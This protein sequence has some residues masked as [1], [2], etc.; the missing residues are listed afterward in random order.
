M[1]RAEQSL[2][3]I[4]TNLTGLTVTGAS[5]HRAFEEIPA[6]PALVLKMESDAVIDSAYGQFNRAL[7]FAVDIQIKK[8]ATAEATFNQIRAEVHKALM[9]DITQGLA[10]IDRTEPVIDDAPAQKDLERP[11]IEQSMHFRVYYSHSTKDTEV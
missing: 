6:V 9:L 2:Q 3:A 10:F 8:S 5:I 1:H 11:I 4:K 7:S